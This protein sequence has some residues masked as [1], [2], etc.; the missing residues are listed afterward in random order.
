MCHFDPEPSIGMRSVGGARSIAREPPSACSVPPSEDSSSVAPGRRPSRPAAVGLDLSTGLGKTI[1]AGLIARRAAPVPEG[2]HHR[3]RGA[4]VGAGAVEGRA[5]GPL[6]TRLRD[7]RPG[8]SLAHAPGARLWCQPVAEARTLALLDESLGGGGPT[9]NEVVQRRLL[10]AATRDIEE[11]LRHLEPRAEES[12]LAATRANCA[13]RPSGDRLRGTRRHFPQPPTSTV[14]LLGAGDRCH[15]RGPPGIAPVLLLVDCPASADLD[16]LFY[17]DLDLIASKTHRLL[18]R[19]VHLLDG[20]LV[21]EVGPGLEKRSKSSNAVVAVRRRKDL[22][23]QSSRN[24]NHEQSHFFHDRP[25]QARI[26][27]VN[28]QDTV[29]R[30]DEGKPESQ[31][32]PHTVAIGTNR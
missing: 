26:D 12:A 20:H 16:V 21:R 25:M 29:C 19:S 23:V 31:K 32:T 4:S 30:P 24:F 8:V 3:R 22:D 17:R 7:S 1:E 9:P 2:Q 15:Q 28:Q 6:R 10:D 14:Q 27:F 18:Q 11:L 5:G 13:E